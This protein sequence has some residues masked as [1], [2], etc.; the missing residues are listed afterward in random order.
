M[1]AT[2]FVIKSFLN[3]M[4]SAN[5]SDVQKIIHETQNLT[6]EFL[7]NEVI[8]D[9]GIYKLLY[10]W[11]QLFGSDNQPIYQ[12]NIFILLADG[13]WLIRVFVIQQMK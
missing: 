7:R 4:T 1:N 13:R 3:K 12:I 9:L 8:D 2:E 11:F 5:G 10:K 6:N